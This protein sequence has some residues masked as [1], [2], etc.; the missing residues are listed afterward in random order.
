MP[1]SHGPRV[2]RRPH[3]ALSRCVRSSARV[4]DTRPTSERGGT[5]PVRLATARATMTITLCDMSTGS[6]VPMLHALSDLLDRGAEHAR[7]TKID[8]RELVT[9]QLAPDMFP[10]VMQVQIACDHAAST[11]A[12]LTGREAPQLENTERTIADLKLRIAKTIDFIESTKGEAFAGTETRKIEVPGP[13][14][15]KFT[16]TG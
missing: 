6:F 8:P 7:A 14:G 5:T 9:A 11:I 16:L 13:P 12:R 15:M 4:P 1:R 10:L 3:T 2:A